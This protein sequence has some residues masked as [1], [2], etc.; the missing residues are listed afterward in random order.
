MPKE[1]PRSYR[2]GHLLQEEIAGLLPEV[3]DLAAA[4]PLPPTVCGVEVA[5]DLRSAKVYFSLMSGPERA[6]A[7]REALQQ[8]AGFIQ[9][10][11]GKRLKMRRIPHLQFV[12]DTRFDRDAEM[13]ALLARLESHD[14]K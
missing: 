7:V 5:P 12:Y 2:V 3:R 13:A 14:G 1:Y 11:L 6:E 4:S 8:A 10:Q 9:R